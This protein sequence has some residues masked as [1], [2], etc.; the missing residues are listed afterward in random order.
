MIAAR[1]SACNPFAKV[2]LVRFY[3]E[4]AEKMGSKGFLGNFR[5]VVANKVMELPVG[6]WPFF[7]ELEQ[8][9][10]ND[11]LAFFLSPLGEYARSSDAQEG[12]GYS[13]LFDVR[14]SRRHRRQRGGCPARRA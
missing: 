4:F 13:N 14:R 9:F 10:A 7:A 1:F 3:R 8:G 11:C 12:V 5:V 2:L 6:P